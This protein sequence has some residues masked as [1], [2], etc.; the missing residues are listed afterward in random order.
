M[1]DRSIVAVKS[2]EE[3]IDS[4][5]SL[6]WENIR[7]DERNRLSVKL[8]ALHTEEYQRW[9]DVIDDV[10]LLLMPTVDAA[11]RK[12]LKSRTATSTEF[13]K[14]VKLDTRL[15]CVEAEYGHL[16]KVDFYA[17]LARWYIAGRFPCGWQGKR[18]YGKLMVF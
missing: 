5:V 15:S 14:V 2:W 4:C 12:V 1:N 11:I 13:G 9:N 8:D 3:A 6:E 10:D 18:P 16:V 7:L 17:T